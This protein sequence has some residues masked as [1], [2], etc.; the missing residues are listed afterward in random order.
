MCD[1]LRFAQ[2]LQSHQLLSAELTRVLLE[3]RVPMGP[4]GTVWYAYGFGCHEVGGIRIVGHNG[5]APGVGAQLD[6][7]LG[8]DYTM[9]LLSNYDAS[10]SLRVVP[11][12]RRLLTG[13]E[14]T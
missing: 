13:T 1:L 7:Y 3:P 11:S 9:A 8:L 5:G 12:I 6:I 10:V 14:G 4:K 2:A